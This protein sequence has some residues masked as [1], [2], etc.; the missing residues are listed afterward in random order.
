MSETFKRFENL[1]YIHEYDFDNLINYICGHL[2]EDY[3]PN[4]G[5]FYAHYNYTNKL[6]IVA[7]WKKRHG[8]QPIACKGE[9]ICDDKLVNFFKDPAH[10]NCFSSTV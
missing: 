2:N 6:C 10:R 4:R 5:Y 8:L 3:L 1:E 7:R 9:A